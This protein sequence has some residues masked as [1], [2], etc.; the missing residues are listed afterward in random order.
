MKKI[1][2][3]GGAGMA[4][5]VIYTYLKESEKY[6]VYTTT[7]QNDF[8]KNSFKFDIFRI[9]DL[10]KI[11]NE[12]N[13]NVVINCIGMLIKSSKSD[14][15]KTIFANSY[16]PHR[17]AKYSRE[18]NFKLIHIS[19]DCVFSGNNGGYTEVSPKD[20]NDIYGM[21]KSLGEIIDDKNI[22][23]RTSIIG[24]EIK[25]N[26]EGLFHWYMNQVDEVT[27]YKS[28][29]WSGVTTYELA[30][31]IDWVLDKDITGLIHL[32]NNNSISK[33]E[34]LNLFNTVYN[35]T[36]VINDNRD[37]VCDKS[38]KNTNLKL[39]Y[40]VP[41]YSN[42]IEEQ[43]KFMENHRDFYKHYE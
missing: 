4:G 18:K 36:I 40:I 34:L 30:K 15:D 29:I 31:F 35:K 11:L 39:N 38:F 6:E 8:G 37:Y 26:G 17:L 23:I 22:T 21:S 2:V 1:L 27:G 13:P 5:H 3:L 10:E 42:M 33:F 9:E 12:V 24:P 28:N 20:A 25:A 41:S 14:P 43:R 32:T 7:N 19:T 16:F